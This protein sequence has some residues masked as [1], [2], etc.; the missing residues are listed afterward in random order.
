MELE[1]LELELLDLDDDFES[2]RRRCRRC[3]LCLDDFALSVFDEEEEE[4]VFLSAS[5]SV[6]G[7]TYPPPS[8]C[9]FFKDILLNEA[10][11]G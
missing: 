11:I 3:R 6:Q 1:E 9:H 5:A 10:R 7:M 2:C 4:D 8:S